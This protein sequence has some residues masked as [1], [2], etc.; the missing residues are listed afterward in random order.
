MRRLR[1][2]TGDGAGP[3]QRAL[4]AVDAAK[5]ASAAGDRE[6]AKRLGETAVTA[7]RSLVTSGVREAEPGLVRALLHQSEHLR[8]SARHA[9]AVAAAEEAVAL[10]WADPARPTSLALALATLAGQLLAAGRPA[11][12]RET[13]REV[14]A[15]SGVQPDEALAQQLSTLASA[16]A[17]AGE[18]E[19]A[20]ALSERSAGM[21]R[22]LAAGSD[23]LGRE[24]TGH[25]DRLYAA[26]R[27]ADAIEFSAEAVAIHRSRAGESPDRLARVLGNYAIMLRRVGR[28]QEALA[29]AAEAE[30][31]AGTPDGPA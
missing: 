13:G 30:S 4:E 11:D 6:T 24:L 3:A 27:W 15:V 21:W 12:A 31:L 20:L 14:L 2:V 23:R 28:E 5:R 9:E 8:E 22:V 18:H 10:A 7:L 1:Q 25:A 29:A 26:G 19:V 16:L 17:G